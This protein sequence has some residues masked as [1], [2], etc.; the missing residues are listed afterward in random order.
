MRVQRAEAVIWRRV[1]A[2]D[3]HLG[4]L[5]EISASVDVGAMLGNRHPAPVAA[6]HGWVAPVSV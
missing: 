1:G 5:A 2:S 3:H 4:R 6:T